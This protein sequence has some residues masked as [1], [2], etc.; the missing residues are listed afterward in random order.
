LEKPETACVVM[1]AL[2]LGF[3]SGLGLGL[4]V[5]VGLGSPAT[6][7]W[8]MSKPLHLTAG[9]AIRCAR[10]GTWLGLGWHLVRVGLAS[11]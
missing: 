6:S 10:A 7:K 4:G 5:R 1:V 2:G 11:G 8:C 3:G 9:I